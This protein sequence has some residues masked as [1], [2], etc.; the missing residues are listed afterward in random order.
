MRIDYALLSRFQLQSTSDQQDLL[1]YPPIAAAAP[2]AIAPEQAASWAY[3]QPSFTDDEIAFTLC[4]AMLGRIYLSG[5]LDHM[6]RE[7]RELVAE[8]VRVHKG[9]R[10]ALAS[11]VP[12]WPL[13][14]PRWTDPWIALGLRTPRAS[15][16]TVWRRGPFDGGS[17]PWAGDQPRIT[18][19]VP[20][21][22]GQRVAADV[23]YPRSTGAG[24]TWEAGAGTLSVQLPRFP[25]ACL[26]R[27]GAR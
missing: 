9:L 11:A 18:L 2:A 24:V 6:S 17:G 1:R 25:S 27:L 4:G 5:H 12:F 23:L 22:R 3:P 26:I 7:Q 16:L 21:L 13:G 19:P 14:L 8:A 15:Y 10:G 20:H